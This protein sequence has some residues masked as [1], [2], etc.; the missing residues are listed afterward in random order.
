MRAL[1]LEHA[2]H[3][4]PGLVG[5][6]LESAG[7]RVERRALHRGAEVPDS[8]EGWDVLV[9]MGG[10]MSVWERE[11]FPFLPAEARLLAES[12]R[13]GRAT[14]GVCLGAQLLALGSGAEV[15][16]GPAPEVGL[17]PIFL[18]DEGR[19]DPLLAPLDGEDV[20]HWHQDTFE[21]PRGALHLA[22]SERYANQAFRLGPRA[23]GVQFHIELDLAARRLWAESGADELR[24]AGVAPASLF[25]PDSAPL[26]ERAR[27]FARAF[28]LLATG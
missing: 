18:T 1:V 23:Y 26:D 10:A 15:R 4:G 11:K 8:P 28:L 24:A 14:L 17:A 5:A 20:L 16:R 25:A 13:S 9:V 6:A 21:L 3:E 19:A 27:A 12:A 22:R 2:D 7:L